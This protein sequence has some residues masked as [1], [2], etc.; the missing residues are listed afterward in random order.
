M[1]SKVKRISTYLLC[2]SAGIV[3]LIS[4]LG[5]IFFAES[6]SKKDVLENGYKNIAGN[7]SAQAM[8]YVLD[9]NTE[10]LEE[11]FKDTGFH[12]WIEKIEDE[13]SEIIFSNAPEN[14]KFTFQ[15]RF[16]S[17]YPEFN[18]QNL[19][20]SISYF[21][22]GRE[23]YT[24]DTFIKSYVFDVN[25]GIFYAKTK[26]GFFEIKY[27]DVKH[28]EL[29]YDYKLQKIDGT[30]CYYNNYYKKMLDMSKMHEWE[31]IR[32][33]D[34]RTYIENYEIIDD[35]A[36]IEAELYEGNFYILNGE[37]IRYSI[38][39]NTEYMV[40]SYI[41]NPDE[42]RSGMFYKWT[43]LIDY[44]YQFEDKIGTY[45][46]VSLLLFIITLVVLVYGTHATRE[47]L[48]LLQKVPVCT[49]TLIMISIEVVI[50]A[51]FVFIFEEL[52]RYSS[53]TLRMYITM[54]IEIA[55]AAI[56]FFLFFITNMTARIKAKSFWRYSEFYYL[57]I[58]FTKCTKRGKEFYEEL[59]RN[60]SLVTK[61]SVFIGILFFIQFFVLL[62]FDY[63]RTV[64]PWFLFYKLIE[65]PVVL[66][67][68]LQMNNLQKGAKCIAD[69]NLA[70]P[71]DT[72]KMFW[73][74][75][76]HGEYINQSGEG[77]S[78]AVEERI[79][80]E[81]LKTE[82]ITNVSHDIKTPLTSIINYV[83][84]IKK[85]NITDET[86]LE[87]IEVLD[88]QSA[89]LK[90][91]IEDLMEASK[92]STGNLACNMENINLTVFL[93]QLVGEFEEKLN[94]IGLEVIITKPEEV[95]YIQADGRHLWRIMEN[96]MN[97]IYKYSLP[98]S[99][100]YINL[101]KH[102][103]M[104]ALVFKNIS[105]TQLNISSDEL[106][107]RF[108]R[109]DSSRNTEGNGLGL[110]IAQSLAELL[111]GTMKLEI[112]GDLFKVNLQFVMSNNDTF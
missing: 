72:T 104:I 102:E 2:A 13:H 91:L 78:L 74:F 108:V 109:G 38:T 95:L 77:I 39:D 73:E 69:G 82:L 11:L 31:W 47:T 21:D 52:G 10:G 97:N 51:L 61:T 88:R 103:Q 1:I 41:E 29:I 33:V 89:R 9:K 16:Y 40:Y 7:Y 92:A 67:V 83:D 22:A 14:A 60:G 42:L 3:F 18:T 56:L 101:E 79:K 45:Q 23:E 70:E 36:S 94:Q 20:K 111:G 62:E 100:V 66:I 8:H 96:L 80:S 81:R 44:V 84:L 6:G 19:L 5:M 50:G 17:T 28:E 57:W 46:V 55:F 71:I 86:L 98:Q 25:K 59:Q 15:H 90:K 58:P 24:E 54:L 49:Y 75:K 63:N 105:K 43:E 64:I 110:S 4:I 27:I 26:A 48:T 68:I 76:K 32:V 35:S 65:I 85:E 37:T 106:I 107:E 53:F 93:G 30:Y 34:S 99:R 12:F 87:Y 112:D